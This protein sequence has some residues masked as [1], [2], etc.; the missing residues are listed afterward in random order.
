MI[1]KIQK[2]IL[3]SSKFSSIK[4]NERESASRHEGRKVKGVKDQEKIEN[5]GE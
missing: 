2:S 3:L 1:K 4:N 5:Q